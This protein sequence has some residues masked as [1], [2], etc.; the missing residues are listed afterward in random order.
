MAKKSK[1]A[2]TALS[3]RRLSEKTKIPYMKIWNNLNE[4]YNSLND[5]EKTIIANAIHDEVTPLLKK[6]GFFIPKIIKIKSE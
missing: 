1:A 2:S 4:N 6:I 3:L 5:D